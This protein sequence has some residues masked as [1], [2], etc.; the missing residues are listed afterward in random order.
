MLLIVLLFYYVPVF[1]SLLR[2]FVVP[3]MVLVRAGAP[4]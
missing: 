4:E 1:M 2:A 3:D